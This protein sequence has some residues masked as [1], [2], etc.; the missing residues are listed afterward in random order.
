MGPAQN[1][2]A[3]FGGRKAP[4]PQ[5]IRKFHFFFQNPAILGIASGK[6][7]IFD[8]VTLCFATVSDLF[9]QKI[10]ARCS[11]GTYY[12]FSIFSKLSIPDP[13]PSGIGQ[14]PK[15]VLYR[16]PPPSTRALLQSLPPGGNPALF[17]EI[18]RE[19]SQTAR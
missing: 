14:N 1:N 11:S 12:F 18:R 8:R 7:V 10:A 2:L 17:S 16:A 3:E 15:I 4:K 5:K 19:G 9:S 13:P 6:G